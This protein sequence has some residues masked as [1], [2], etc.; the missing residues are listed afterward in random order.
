MKAYTSIDQC[1][2]NL[3]SQTV[4]PDPTVAWNQRAP[5]P[6][7]CPILNSVVLLATI[8]FDGRKFHTLILCYWWTPAGMHTGGWR[9]LISKAHRILSFIGSL[10]VL[11]WYKWLTT[12]TLPFMYAR[13]SWDP[14]KR[15]HVSYSATSSLHLCHLTCYFSSCHFVP[16]L[17]YI[18]MLLSRDASFNL[19]LRVE[20]HRCG[21][22]WIERYWQR[23]EKWPSLVC[24]ADSEYFAI[25]IIR[26]ASFFGVLSHKSPCSFKR[27]TLPFDCFPKKCSQFL[28]CQIHITDHTNNFSQAFLTSSLLHSSKRNFTYHR[29]MLKMAK[30][31]W[32]RNWVNETSL[33]KCRYHTA[34]GR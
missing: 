4:H 10:C 1:F 27:K 18:I 5:S 30:F 17:S 22:A 14:G 9:F 31:C 13:R 19:Y 26:V 21:P 33:Q 28:F 12:K 7:I 15:K 11:R 8:L 24:Q 25:V 20:G 16:Y 6:W 32:F 29:E 3:W 34:E 23:E 2:R